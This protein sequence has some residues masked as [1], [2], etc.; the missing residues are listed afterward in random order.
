MRTLLLVL[1]LLLLALAAGL[2]LAL[3]AGAQATP[4]GGVSLNVA[5]DPTEVP[6]GVESLVE[7]NIVARNE[8]AATLAVA[9]IAFTPPSAA[10]PLPDRY[11]FFS[12]QV[13]GAERDTSG[14]GGTVYEVGDIAPGV[15][16]V[17]TVRVIVRSAGDFGADVVLVTGA[18]GRDLA[19]SAVNIAVRGEAPPVDVKLLDEGRVSSTG[20]ISLGI[21]MHN[22][23]QDAIDS[24]D[25]E[26]APG[27]RVTASSGRMPLARVPGTLDTAPRYSLSLGTIAPG[28]IFEEPLS[29]RSSSNPCDPAQPAVLVTAHLAGGRTVRLAARLAATTGLIPPCAAALG[30]NAA[31][32][33]TGTGPAPDALGAPVPFPA[34]L[35]ATVSALSLAMAATARRAARTSGRRLSPRTRPQPPAERSHTDPR[36]TH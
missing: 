25:V 8:G 5:C 29:L 33:A 18:E 22:R 3:P 19:R 6:A 23:S 30:P 35:L 28:W 4:G 13:D 14:G 2:G 26:F 34:A 12:V 7:C 21:Q 9:R 16:R 24:S 32:P 15:E 11:Y 31:L 17:V 1:L 20:A 27:G 36:L 10:V